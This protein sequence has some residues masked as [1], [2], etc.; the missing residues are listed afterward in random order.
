MKSHTCEY[1]FCEGIKH[2]ELDG[3]TYCQYVENV[4]KLKGSYVLDE[5]SKVNLGAYRLIKS[6]LKAPLLMPPILN[7]SPKTILEDL[8]IPGHRLTGL[9]SIYSR[10][11]Y[12]GKSYIPWQFD[13]VMRWRRFRCS[14]GWH[15]KDKYPLC[16]WCSN[17]K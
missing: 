4:A 5:V 2:K 9:T 14:V 11:I 1:S 13:L 16:K 17:E 10:I 8:Y 15:K 7:S 6:R 3:L 12:E